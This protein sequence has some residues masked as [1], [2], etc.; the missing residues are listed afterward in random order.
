MWL[1]RVRTKRLG[2][3]SWSQPESAALGFSHP[4]ACEEELGLVE[5]G[6]QEPSVPGASAGG[7]SNT[8]CGGKEPGSAEALIQGQ[9]GPESGSAGPLNQGQPGP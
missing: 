6:G 1:R 5:A 4:A 9:T 2:V 8:W 7:I 3:C